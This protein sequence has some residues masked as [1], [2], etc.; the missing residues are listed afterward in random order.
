VGEGVSPRVGATRHPPL[1][2]GSVK[3]FLSVI[4][5]H[6]SSG[7]ELGQKKGEKGRTK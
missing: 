1:E 4:G 6:H 3:W 5:G 7:S 2:L